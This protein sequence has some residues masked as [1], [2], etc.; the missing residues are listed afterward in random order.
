LRGI[1]ESKLLDLQY[2]I[3]KLKKDGVAQI[4]INK[5]FLEDADFAGTLVYEQETKIT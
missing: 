1:I 2:N 3:T 5:R 4:I